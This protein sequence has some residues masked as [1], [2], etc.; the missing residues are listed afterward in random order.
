M[1]DLFTI[2]HQVVFIAIQWVEMQ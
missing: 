1:M 2:L